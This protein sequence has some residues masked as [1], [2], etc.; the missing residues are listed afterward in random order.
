MSVT[1]FPPKRILVIDDE[2]FVCEA[3]K[4]M[5]N[6]DGHKVQTAA[7]PEEA[8]GMFEAGKFDLLI[9]DYSMPGMKG[10][11]LAQAIKQLDPNLPVLMITAY[12]E[13]LPSVIKG[14]DH[15]IGK[16]FLL[17]NLRE[18]ISKVSSSRRP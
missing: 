17:E 8:L 9:T 3:V 14:V 7:S 5:L 12:A 15:I 4:M 10:D 2:A 13:V 11:A 18:A 6:F 16:P 1:A